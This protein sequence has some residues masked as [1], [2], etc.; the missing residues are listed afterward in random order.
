MTS[1]VLLI[2]HPTN[3]FWVNFQTHFSSPEKAHKK[4]I[5]EFFHDELRHRLRAEC[6]KCLFDARLGQNRSWIS[7]VPGIVFAHSSL[8]LRPIIEILNLSSA[9]CTSSCFTQFP[10]RMISRSQQT[11]SHVISIALSGCRPRISPQLNYQLLND[12]SCEFGM[13][14][15][16]LKIQSV[17]I[18]YLLSGQ[19]FVG[20]KKFDLRC[21]TK[22]STQLREFLWQIFAELLGAFN[23]ARSAIE[24]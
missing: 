4:N 8:A 12:R 2:K 16:F 9:L 18:E 10:I 21:F 19:S 20:R 11:A 7:K 15:F 1:L 5:F 6:Q 14:I 22:I 13:E 17:F 23:V 24:Q 3:V